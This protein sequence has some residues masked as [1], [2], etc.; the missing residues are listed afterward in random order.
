M[1]VAD[2]RAFNRF[3][4]GVIG[5]LDSAY[6]SSPYS[7]TE[8]RV[9]FELSR[10]TTETVALRTGL[11]LDAGYLS[12]ILGRFDRE[13][14][15]TRAP[16][17]DDARRQVVGLTEAGRSALDE[18]DVRSNAEIGALLAGVPDSER[19]ALVAAMGKIRRIL[20]GAPRAYRLRPLRPGDLGW[21][22]HRHGVRYAE[23]YGY[24]ETFE[25]LVARVVAEY[26]ERHDPAREAAWI[27]EV[28]GEPVGSIFCVRADE[29]TAQLRLLLVEPSARGLGIGKRL[30]EECV[31]FATRVGYRRMA[32]ATVSE[33][34]VARGIYRRAGFEP[35]ASVPTR[36]W[37]KDVVEETWAKELGP[38]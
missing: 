12:R 21:V 25:A 18:L 22:V 29:R 11:G 23:E 27:A 17:P 6:L 33:V 10:G 28:D 35:V 7:L 36:K 37:G 2:V 9:L 5:V 1:T 32:L 19:N 26:V 31:R 16:S 14:L 24:D 20:T 13:G 3:Y 38:T 30:V 4:T 15:I 34:D 8:V